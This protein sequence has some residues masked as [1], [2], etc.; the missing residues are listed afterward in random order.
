[1]KPFNFLAKG[2]K[3]QKSGRKFTTNNLGAKQRFYKIIVV[4]IFIGF[5]GPARAQNFQKVSV[6]DGM[7]ASLLPSVW[8]RPRQIS[9]LAGVNFYKPDRVLQ[10]R[11]FMS[12]I[13]PADQY[14]RDFGFFCRKELQFEKHVKIPLRFRLGSLEYCNSLEAKE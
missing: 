5:E 13:L 11:L 4:L 6:R 12:R 3:P 1:L 10:N 14:T 9:P 8:E 2:R 7:Q